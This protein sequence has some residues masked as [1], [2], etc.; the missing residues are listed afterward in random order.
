[1]RIE[2]V[3]DQGI[4]ALRIQEKDVVKAAKRLIIAQRSRDLFD[5]TLRLW[6]YLG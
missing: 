2:I 6:T 1:M 3:V 5:S 4:Q